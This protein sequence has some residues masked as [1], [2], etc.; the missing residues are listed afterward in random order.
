MNMNMNIINNLSNALIAIDRMIEMEQSV[1]PKVNKVNGKYDI[2]AAVI[3][4]NGEMK[5]VIALD[6]GMYLSG[7]TKFELETRIKR[8]NKEVEELTGRQNAD[9]EFRMEVVEA[10]EAEGIARHVA[11]N[12]TS[13]HQGLMQCAKQYGVI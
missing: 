11:L 10:M 8:R 9:N 6:N 13:T 1:L 2:S 3:P 12:R 7:Y 5:Y 4:F